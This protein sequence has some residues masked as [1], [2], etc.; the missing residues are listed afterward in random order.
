ML[1]VI[2]NTVVLTHRQNGFLHLRIKD[3]GIGLDNANGTIVGNDREQPALTVRNDGRKSHLEILRVH[4]SREAVADGLLLTSGNLNGVTSS[5]QVTNNL[6]LVIDVSKATSNEVH[7]DGVR[8]IIGN[9]DERLGW[10]T[11]DKLDTKDLGSRE[12]CLDRDSRSGNLCFDILS[13]L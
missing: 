6:G 10:V 11:V 2:V 1:A 4:L 8:L 7:R 13:I 3:A 12:G 9:G 5:S